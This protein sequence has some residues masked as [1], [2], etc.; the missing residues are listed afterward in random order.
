MPVAAD[1]PTSS[2]TTCSFEISL[3]RPARWLF[4]TAAAHTRGRRGGRI[5]VWPSLPG[6]NPCLIATTTIAACKWAQCEAPLRQRPPAASLP[7]PWMDVCQLSLTAEAAPATTARRACVRRQQR[8]QTKRLNLLQPPTPRGPELDG[9]GAARSN[10]AGAVP[11]TL[12]ARRAPAWT[13]AGAGTAARVLAAIAIAATG[14]AD[15][16][17][18]L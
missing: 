15:R 13:A 18:I 10:S 17:D 8:P 3:S 2:A 4:S 6:H 14:L 7:G 12:T 1:P 9:Q 5:G 11:P 16:A